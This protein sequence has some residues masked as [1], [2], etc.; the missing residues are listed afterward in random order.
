[1]TPDEFRAAGHAMVDRIAAYLDSVGEQRIV[2]DIAPGDVYAALP[3]TAPATTTDV[4]TLMADIDRVIIPNLSHWQHPGWFAYFPANTSYASIL[5]ELLSAGLGVQG[6]SWVTSPAATEVETLMCDWMLD[7]LGLPRSFRSD[8]AT[9]GGVIQGSASEAT[10]VAILAARWRATQGAVNDTGDT[11][12][13]VAYRTAQAHSSIDK[14]L[15]IAGIGEQR[16]R[17]VAHD[18]DLAMDPAD[19]AR[20]MTA[21]VDAGLQPFFVCSTHGTTSTLAMDPTAAIADAIDT[22]DGAG[23]HRVWLHVDAAMAGIA[24]LDPDQRWV[25]DGVDRADSYCTNP[26]KWMGVNFDCTLFWTV[27]RHA[28]LGA[29]SILPAYLRSTAADSGAI[30]YRDWQIPLGRRFRALKLLFVL[31]LDGVEPIIEML[32][33]HL[34]LANDLAARVAAHP[35]LEI[36]APPRL[37]LVCLSHID[38]DAATD[39]LID[40][41]NASGRHLVTRTEVDGRSL[42]RVSIGARTTAAEHVDALWDDIH[43]HS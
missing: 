8:T 25:N 1:M 28:M 24:A 2:P 30:D 22:V 19:L 21:D 32:R 18:A 41:V 39:A 10:L 40:A 38:G 3:S 15:R 4:D 35:R 43:A 34:R 16:I 42:L 9:G 33:H 27:D 26:H 36:A 17:T 20:Q 14:G 29:L 13:L 37:G 12:R 5:A 23:T 11:S 6:M 7:L 31:R